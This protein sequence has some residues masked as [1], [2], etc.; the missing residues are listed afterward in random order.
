MEDKPK[1]A[2]G[3]PQEYCAEHLLKAREYIDSCYDVDEDKEN[4]IKG[5]VKIPTKG[6]LA[7]H[8]KVARE[9]LYDWSDKFKEFSDVMEELGAIQEDRLINNGLKGTY[10][11]T[12]SKVLLTKHGYREGID[13]TTDNK[14][15][16]TIDSKDLLKLANEINERNSNSRTS[17]TSHGTDTESMGNKV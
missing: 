16:Q 8:L 6:G 11:P 10:N 13:N 2:G 15:I 14:P 1:H 4:Q 17:I 12:I 7:F 3:R 5:R 9:T